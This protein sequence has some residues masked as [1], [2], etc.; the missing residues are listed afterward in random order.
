[1][2]LALLTERGRDFPTDWLAQLR[3]V[4]PVSEDHS[5][6][7]PLWYVAGQ[8]WVLY[9]GTP[10]AWLKANPGAAV[11]PSL[12]A[13]D[14][15]QAMEGPPPSNAPDLRIRKR[16]SDVQ[17]K[18]WRD[19]RAFVQPYFVL[20]G[21]DG[22]HLTY[23][24]PEQQR[25]LSTK[26][27]RTTPPPIGRAAWQVQMQEWEATESKKEYP[28]PAPVYLHAC[29]FDNRTMT[30][31]RRANRLWQMNGNVDQLKRSGDI[32]LMERE[33]EE[34]LK[35]IRKA[36]LA[37]IEQFLIPAT[38]AATG[39]RKKSETRD[40]LVYL[41]GQAEAADERLQYWEETGQFVA[42]V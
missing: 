18:A 35:E 7:V 16:F 29:P 23:F 9:E 37:A 1:M 24:T 20:Q 17:W 14:V 10:I 6:L 13:D 33:E 19:H 2:T 21:E 28:L 42:K 26:H 3:S 34:L 39:L 12:I 11:A 40:E 41:D 25:L 27:L 22:G 5:F 4:S 32:A 8:R 38:E 30:H 15:I 36:E 31:L